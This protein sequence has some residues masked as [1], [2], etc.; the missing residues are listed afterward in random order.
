MTFLSTTMK[1]A[2][3]TILAICSCNGF[4]GIWNQENWGQMY[5]G[6]NIATAP[7]VA[8][9]IS[10]EVDSDSIIVSITNYLEGSGQDGWSAIMSYTVAC[11]DAPAVTATNS[12]IQVT[13]LNEEETYNC[14]VV[15]TNSVG[16]S[17]PTNF[18]EQTELTSGG[19]PIWLLYEASKPRT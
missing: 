14:T 6:T 1:A 5:W 8:P 12:P 9:S 2:I 3:G 10:T 15:A 18:S 17:I 4:A 16:D 19:L 13:G 7:L 11:G